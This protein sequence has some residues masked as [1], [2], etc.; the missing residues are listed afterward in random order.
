MQV[1]LYLD[2]DASSR[3]LARGLRARGIDVL[4]AVEA[5]RLEE[6]DPNQLDF[7]TQ[8]GRAIYTYNVAHFYRLHTTWVMGAKAVRE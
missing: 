3:S 6:D 7:A 8:Q 4:T 1:R 5:G 2:E